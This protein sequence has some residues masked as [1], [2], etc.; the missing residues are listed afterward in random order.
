[1]T[2]QALRKKYLQ[3]RT[4]LSIKERA[5]LDQQLCDQFFRCFDFSSIKAIHLYAPM[6]KF[7]EPNTFL[8]LDKLMAHYPG[9]TVALPKVDAASSTLISLPYRGHESLSLGAWGI[10]EPTGDESI[11]PTTFD[12]VIVPL[13]AYDTKGHRLGYGKGYYDQFLTT[14]RVECLKVGLSY[15][16]PTKTLLPSESHDIPLTH[17]VTPARVLNF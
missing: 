15:F 6:E 9:I 5:Q 12:M 11:D 14:C 10:P 7:A 16:E 4:S 13:L 3:K 17:M 8:L 1:M 2:K